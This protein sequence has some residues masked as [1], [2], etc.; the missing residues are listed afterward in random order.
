MKLLAFAALI[1]ALCS[2]GCDAPYGDGGSSPRGHGPRSFC[3][4]FTTCGTCT[5]VLGCGWCQSGSK[6]LCAEDPD[7]CEGAESFSWSWES[8]T[9]PGAIDGGADVS[10]A[11][12][13]S[14]GAPAGS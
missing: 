14:D 4:R 6:G 12:A 8:A 7:V 5:P 9:C 13:K 11:P 1:G 10:V 3:A 2:L